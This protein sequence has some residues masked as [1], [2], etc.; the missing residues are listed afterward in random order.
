MRVLQVASEAAPFAK[1]GGL[2][3]VVGALPGAL[4]RLG[5][6]VTVVIPAHR[7][8]FLSRRLPIESTGWECDVAV[9]TRKQ[10][11]KIFL[12][13]LGKQYGLEA[14]GWR[15][16]SAPYGEPGAL[17]SVADIVDPASLAKVRE[18]KRAAKAAAKAS[19]R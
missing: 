19:S 2:A 5:C 14:E 1:T 3:D 11:A 15:P 10:K 17:R 12:A 18:H 8:A 13:L 9:G 4:S 7:E 16:A 6:H